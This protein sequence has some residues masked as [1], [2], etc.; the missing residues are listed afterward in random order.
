MIGDDRAVLFPTVDGYIETV[1]ALF[2]DGF[3]TCIDLT[4]VDYLTHPGRSLP[5]G[6]E[7]QRLELVVSFLHHVRRER[8]RVRVQVDA[9]HAVVPTLFDIF[10]GTESMEREVFDMFGVTFTDHPDMTRILMP[11]SW[12]GHPLLK[13]Y[14]VGE[15]PVQFKAVER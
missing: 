13:D 11:E 3:N 5:A 10:P 12:L 1:E 6:I 14:A 15:I 4:A 9:D 8:V 2:A 7:P